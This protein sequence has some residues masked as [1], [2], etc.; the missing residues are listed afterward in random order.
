MKRLR[1]KIIPIQ[2]NRHKIQDIDIALTFRHTTTEKKTIG[3][4]GRRGNQFD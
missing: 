2:I 1:D 4:L 3:N